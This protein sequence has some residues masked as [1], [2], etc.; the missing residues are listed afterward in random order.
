[1]KDYSRSILNRKPKNTSKMTGLRSDNIL[2]VDD[3][4][5][6]LELYKF[7]FENEGMICQ[8]ASDPVDA[9]NL[10]KEQHFDTVILDFMLPTMRGDEIAEKI[11][12]MDV[13]AKIILVSGYRN[14]EYAF[15]E[16]NIKIA[17]VLMKP[18][19]PEELLRCV[20]T[21]SLKEIP[22]TIP[23]K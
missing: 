15:L 8:T 19:S 9:L 22:L 21:A 6:I 2:I 12:Q 3:D 23:I 13:N 10:I 14:A 4:Q 20:K 5:D 17:G 7:I 11:Q 16:K 18:V 1:M